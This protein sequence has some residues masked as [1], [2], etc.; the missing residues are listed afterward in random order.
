VETTRTSLESR[1]DRELTEAETRIDAIRDQAGRDFREQQRRREEFRKVAGRIL[2]RGGYPLQKL[3]DRFENA[4]LTRTDDHGGRHVLV[5]FKHTPRFPATAE[6]RVDIAHDEEIR[7]VLVFCDVKI[8]P[9]FLDFDR[10]GS[11]SFDLSA[12]DDEKL[13]GWLE[14]RIVAFVRDYLRIPFVEEYQREN[15]VTDPVSA[16]RFSKLFA[17]GEAVHRGHTY[18]F[19]SPETKAAFEADPARWVHG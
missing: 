9:V 7:K 2:E 11:I 15:L 18:H 12:V 16:Q 13:L 8:L 3:A 10:G 14:D 5:R 6:L 17:A 1:I 4:E 19:L